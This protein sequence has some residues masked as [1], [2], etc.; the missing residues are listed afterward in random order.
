MITSVAKVIDVIG[1][2]IQ[3]PANEAAGANVITDEAVAD[4]AH[5]LDAT[6]L[7][8]SPIPDGNVCGVAPGPGSL[9]RVT[10]DMEAMTDQDLTRLWVLLMQMKTD[11]VD[12]TVDRYDTWQDAP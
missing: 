8:A 4:A 7:L 1:R 6:G 9:V 10:M 5:T 2:R 12:A 11:G 3:W